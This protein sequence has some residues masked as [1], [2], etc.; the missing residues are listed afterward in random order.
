MQRILCI[1]ALTVPLMGIQQISATATGCSWMEQLVVFVAE[2]TDYPPLHICPNVRV[3][4]KLEL[5][6]IDSDSSAHGA[7][8]LAAYLPISNEILIGADID[9]TS[10]RGRSYL[11]HEI[12]HSAQ[13]NSGD[14]A[15][16]TCIGV[17][18]SEAYRVQAI[19]LTKHD[20]AEEARV[21]LWMSVMH[22][23][24]CTHHDYYR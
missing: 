20:L 8:M 9:L 21:F 12:V 1:M 15:P 14:T 7:E 16:E 6:L 5:E 19:Y 2:E 18:E 11:V 23:S 22:N 4:A 24:I 13:F 10:L 17:L 3:T